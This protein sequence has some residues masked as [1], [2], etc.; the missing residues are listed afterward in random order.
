MSF[1]LRVPVSLGAEGEE[2]HM[3]V[4]AVRSSYVANLSKSLRW[5]VWRIAYRL[6]GDSLY[7]V[8][9]EDV[10]AVESCTI[11]VSFV[12]STLESRRIIWC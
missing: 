8:S 12:L 2:V 9:V 11:V 4:P 3:Y 1:A 5:I 10:P 6:A 7:F